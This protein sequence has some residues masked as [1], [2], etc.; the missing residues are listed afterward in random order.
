MEAVKLLAL[1]LLIVIALRLKLSVGVTLLG[2]GVVTAIL[3]SVSAMDLLEGYW[4]LAQS[5]KFIFLTSVVLLITFL[6]ALLKEV[7]YLDRLSGACRGL[8]GGKRTAA[9][10]LPPLI[11]LMPMPGGALL[12]APLVD[13]VL[14]EPRYKPEFRTVTNY[15]FRHIA[16]FAWPLYPGLIL[17]EAITGMPI[18]DVA[19]MQLP[20]TVMMVIVGLLFFIRAIRPG[21][22]GTSRNGSA[23]MG[24]LG[25]LWPIVL[26]IA[27][28]GFTGIQLAWAV[29]ISV[30]LLIVVVRPKLPALLTAA[31][32]GFSYKLV[33]LIFGTLSFQT[34]L[35]LA[36]A[37][38]AIPR[39]ATSYNLPPELIIILVCVIAGLL[40][41]MVAAY[42]ALGYTILAGFMYQPEIIPGH[43]MLA[44]LSGFVG[45]MLSPAHLCLIL[46][47]EYF[48]SDL[49]RV[50]RR[51][52]PPL[53][54]VFLGGILL[55]FSGW[56]ELFASR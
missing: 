20:L 8:Y 43:I 41:G 40:T 1:F 21:T 54:L 30:G 24:I 50:Y 27:V 37:I 18:G 45:M 3:Y 26:A 4:Q 53:V 6:G 51:L 38:E 23:L 12:S 19:V 9:T 52:A 56:P 55:Y 7:G 5:K 11:G 2:A 36:G 42:V 31:R 35:E 46:T 49:G 28:Y 48:K 44:Y 29:L 39:L 16:E 13:K 22:A 32:R 25:A 15:W 17:S 10:V 14:S 47:N 34:A 33:L